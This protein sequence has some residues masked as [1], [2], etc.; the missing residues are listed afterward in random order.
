MENTCHH[1]IET[2]VNVQQ[3]NSN[4]PFIASSFHL[5]D[6]LCVAETAVC[7]ELVD[8]NTRKLMFKLLVLI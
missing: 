4:K 1:K 5:L 3:E 2:V 6:I 8:E 7:S